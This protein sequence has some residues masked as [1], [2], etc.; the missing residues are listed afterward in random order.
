MSNSRNKVYLSKSG[1]WYARVNGRRQTL[2]TRAEHEHLLRIMQAEANELARNPEQAASASSEDHRV[3]ILRGLPG[4]GKTTWAREFV[5]YHGW[6]RCVSKD[7]LRE[8]FDFGRYD[9]DKEKL[10]RKIQGR[11]IRELLREG[12]NVVVDNTNLSERDIREIK[13][14]SIVWWQNK[15][16]LSVR[17]LEFHTPIEECIRRDALRPNPVGATRIR[18]LAERYRWGDPE[19]DEELVEQRRE[20]AATIERLV[21]APSWAVGHEDLYQ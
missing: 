5:K 15:T 12:L 20:M 18:E 14:A 2:N 4:S 19:R 11:L 8:M 17:I 6:Y 3:I 16:Y 7:G 10:I 9:F 13:D 21:Q 1:S